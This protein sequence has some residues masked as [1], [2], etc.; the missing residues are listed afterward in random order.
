MEFDYEIS[1]IIPA[2]NAEKTIESCLNNII[3]E[4]KNLSSEIIVIDDCSSDKTLEKLKQFQSIKVVKLKKNKVNQG[5]F[6]ENPS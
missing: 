4:T 6:S 1:I 3:N 5:W 2:Y